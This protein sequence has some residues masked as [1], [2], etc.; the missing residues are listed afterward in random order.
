MS[1]ETWTLAAACL[2]A[3][4]LLILH[5]KTRSFHEDVALFAEDFRTKLYLIESAIRGNH[6]KTIAAVKDV[7]AQVTKIFVDPIPA[8]PFPAMSKVEE[9]RQLL[10]NAAESRD[11]AT[12]ALCLNSENP[13]ATER[14]LINLTAP[15]A[16]AEHRLGLL[17]D[18]TL[19]AKYATPTFYQ[20]L[21]PFA[22]A[23]LK[24]RLAGQELLLARMGASDT[25][26]FD[27]ANYSVIG[28]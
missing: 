11:P 12:L 22:K 23:L 1:K 21:K 20:S 24:G 3:I 26:S 10:L 8:T 19:S 4:L 25:L 9:S 15:A 7:P 13:E 16:T 18:G 2:V 17:V 5:Y 6:A 27:G 28:T 14:V